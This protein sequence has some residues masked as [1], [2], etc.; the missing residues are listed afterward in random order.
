MDVRVSLTAT[1]LENMGAFSY[2]SMDFSTRGSSPSTASQT[3]AGQQPVPSPQPPAGPPVAA[4]P[5]GPEVTPPAVDPLEKPINVY[6]VLAFFSAQAPNNPSSLRRE[7][8]LDGADHTSDQLKNLRVTQTAAYKD[9]KKQ[10]KRRLM[11]CVVTTVSL[12]ALAVLFAKVDVNTHIIKI[13]TTASEGVA[14]IGTAT[15]A[16]LISIPMIYMVRLRHKNYVAEKTKMLNAIDLT[17]KTIDAASDLKKREN[18]WIQALQKIEQFVTQ[19]YEINIK[20]V[21]DEFNA[22]Q[23]K[24]AKEY[25]ADYEQ[26]RATGRVG[27]CPIPDKL[28]T[29]SNKILALREDNVPIAPDLVDQI[30]SEIQAQ[31]TEIS[32]QVLVEESDQKLSDE[33]GLR[34]FQKLCDQIKSLRNQNFKFK[35]PSAE[36]AW[37]KCLNAIPKSV[38]YELYFEAIGNTPLAAAHIRRINNLPEEDDG[39]V[40]V[41]QPNLRRTFQSMDTTSDASSDDGES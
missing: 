14:L 17:K 36:R 5:Q 32:Q 22:D 35:T 27:Y 1:R 23:E 19:F 7:M 25:E 38:T 30:N 40:L 34:S 31:I 3:T 2:A 15:S 33:D 11:F 26:H 37:E 16:S 28:I 4:D 29:I 13:G 18:R 6:E 24:A 10:I 12:I 21:I 8:E 9:Q 39:F 20:L 41:S